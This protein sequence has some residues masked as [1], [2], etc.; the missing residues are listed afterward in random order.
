MSRLYFITSNNKL[1]TCKSCLIGI[2][3]KKNATRVMEILRKSNNLKDTR[4]VPMD[5]MHDNFYNMLKFNQL[6][7][8]IATDVKTYKDNFI[9]NGDLID[10]PDVT[11]QELVKHLEK[12]YVQDGSK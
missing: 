11:N 3:D 6:D 7:I 8:I 4:V 5:Y 2:P 12:I 9:L 10:R 1:F